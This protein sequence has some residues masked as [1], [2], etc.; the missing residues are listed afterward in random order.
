MQ[1]KMINGHDLYD[2]IVSGA[3]KIITNEK[4]LNAI[5]VFPVADGDT[6]SNLAYTMKCII[7]KAERHQSVH[8]ALQGISQV[9]LEDSYGN[10]GAIFASYLNGLSAEA[11]GREVLTLKEFSEMAHN[12]VQYAYDAMAKPVEGTILTV[13]K[14]WASYLKD[15]HPHETSIKRL[16]HNA[17]DYTVEILKE[18]KHQLKVLKDAN[19]VDAGAQAFVYFLEGIRDFFK[20]GLVHTDPAPYEEAIHSAHTDLTTRYCTEWLLEPNEAYQQIHLMRKLD[21]MSDSLI[22]QKSG[23]LIK[24]HCHTDEPYRI[25]EALTPMGTIIKT[26]VDDMVIQQAI[27]SQG[28]QPIGII[29]DTI[30]DLPEAWLLD[31][32]ILRIPLLMNLDGQIYSDRYAL[33][34]DQLFQLVPTLAEHPKSAQPGVTA[35]EK[36]LTFM[37]DHF[38]HVVGV[39][40]SDQMSGLY[41]KVLLAAKDLPQDR[42]TLINSKTNSGAQGLLVHE[43]IKGLKKGVNPTAL[44]E[45]L[46]AAIKRLKIF[47]QIPDL[48]YATLSG[49]VPKIV[50]SISSMFGLKVIISIDEEGKGIVTKELSLKRAV[51]KFLA[52]KKLEHYA[53]V[54]SGN[55][56]EATIYENMMRQLTGQDP[57]YVE[58]VST[59]VSAF[60]G[61][62]SVGLAL[63][64]AKQ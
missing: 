34:N 13:I 57:L 36:Q 18:T 25:T 1:T 8:L 27:T 51:Q 7:A 39:F 2:Y 20:F 41:Q 60:V 11:K 48:H 30:A 6:G 42:V 56:E 47:V 15:N 61:E 31:Y 35:I 53:I 14:A 4:G 58:Q 3:K 54:H 40:V 28:R 49:R 17:T 9:A 55:L 23:D 26:K 63:L 5:N 22:V 52:G 43:V 29:T 45:H 24:I 59:V 12:A 50:G 37:L 44:K 62:G 64:E 16:F 21:K 38:D 33:T 19:V 32:Q 10:S 46:E